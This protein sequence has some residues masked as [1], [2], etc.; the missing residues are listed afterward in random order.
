MGCDSSAVSCGQLVSPASWQ[1]LGAFSWGCVSCKL[2][3]LW[4]KSVQWDRLYSLDN[5]NIFNLVTDQLLASRWQFPVSVPVDRS[6]LA[7]GSYRWGWKGN[8]NSAAASSSWGEVV[9]LWSHARK[10]LWAFS[11]F[12]DSVVPGTQVKTSLLLFPIP[13]VSLL[14]CVKRC[15]KKPWPRD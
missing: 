1:A 10:F 15:V 9:P 11:W 2:L 14:W 12:S 4:A 7:A 8:T 6:V 13:S 3:V 5:S